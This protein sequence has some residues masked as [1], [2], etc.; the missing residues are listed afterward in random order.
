[1]CSTAVTP[2]NTSSLCQC[3]ESAFNLNSPF[4]GSVKGMSAVFSGTKEFQF[5]CVFFSSQTF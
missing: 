5:C 4:Q 2:H 3:F 1:M